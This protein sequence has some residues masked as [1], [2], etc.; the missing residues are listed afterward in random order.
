MFFI[1]A[2]NQEFPLVHSSVHDED[3]DDLRLCRNGDEEAYARIVRRYEIVIARQMWRF[4]RDS[5]RHE[6]LVQEVFVE[7]YTSL[8]TFKAT[9]PFEYWLRKIAT[10]VGYRFW[11][12][13]TRDNDRKAI[14][15]QHKE[16]IMPS[17]N[18]AS[19]SEA[20]EYVH[21]LLES[22]EAKDRVVLTLLYFEGWDTREIAEHLGWSQS[23]V[24]VRAFRARKKLKKKL[25]VAGYVKA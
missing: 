8:H 25:E 13:K 17:L 20:G 24:K 10:R 4:S 15:Y 9:A 3:R 18:A 1:T 5:L 23:S 11:K 21:H 2:L 19:P 14:V 6:E 7:A 16:A 12:H 22:L